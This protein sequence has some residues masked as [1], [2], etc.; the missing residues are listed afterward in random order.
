MI[1]K[2]EARHVEDLCFQWAR[3]RVYNENPG[4]FGTPES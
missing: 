2:N 4:D 1:V 3:R